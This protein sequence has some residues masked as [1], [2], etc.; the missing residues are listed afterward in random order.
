MSGFFGNLESEYDRTYS[1]VE[2]LKRYGGYIKEHK[3][4]LFTTIV[5]IVP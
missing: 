5:A 3:K 4:Y 2:L 1:D